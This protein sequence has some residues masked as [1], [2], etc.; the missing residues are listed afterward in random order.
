[1][2]VPS[3]PDAEWPALQD[4]A[5]EFLQ[6]LVR[7]HTIN[8]D[9][10]ANGSNEVGVGETVADRLI[11]NK[12][13][14]DGI[15]AEILEPKPGRGNIIARLKGDGSR[16]PVLLLGHL[17]VAGVTRADWDP[18]I[19]PFGGEIKDGR[20][21]GR[22]AA[23][24]KDLVVMHV[25]AMLVARR[26]NLRLKRDL[27]LAGVADEEG[28]SDLGMRWL[29]ANHWD[30]IAAE[31]SLN[32]GFS[33]GPQVGR[34]GKT[35]IW[36]GL[37]A[38]EKRI[39]VAEITASGH[40]GHA[41]SEQADNSIYRLA[42]ALDGLQQHPRPMVLNP[43]SERFVRTIKAYFGQD[44]RQSSAPAIR[45][46]FHDAIVPTLL[47][48]GT[49]LIVLPGKASATL[50]CRLLPTTDTGEF[51][52]WLETV[53]GLPN[54]EV[55]YPRGT[56]PPSPAPS[57]FENALVT[58]YTNMVHRHFGERVPVILTQG[59]GTTDSFHM[60]AKGVAAYGVRPLVDT[61]A[62]NMHGDNESIPVEDS[63][64]GCECSS[65]WS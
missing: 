51:K 14:Q 8:P 29:V 40:A 45:A 46:M 50:I 6:Q 17:D 63:G 22:G 53:V 20:L 62:E 26:R 52:T 48:G 61:M 25:M 1:M 24:M 49:D 31:F 47:S 42:A 19:D 58:T 7:V 56:P 27:I 55:T 10:L 32:E 23:D 13:A 30:K 9:D 41:S 2:T 44:L 21:F 4:E 16:K 36:V 11:Q 43:V 38:I 64:Q 15:A 60:R 3:I 57:P 35:I 5:I 54:V 39:L 33:G 18:A 37:E 65:N 34:D 59:T 28:G 12:L